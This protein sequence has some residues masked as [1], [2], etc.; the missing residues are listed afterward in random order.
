MSIDISV[1]IFVDRSGDDD[2]D[3]YAYYEQEFRTINAF[4]RTLGLPEHHE[5]LTLDG[6]R[7][8]YRTAKREMYPMKDIASDIEA[9]TVL[10]FPHL[11]ELSGEDAI[12]LPLLFENVLE[13][14]SLRH[15][16]S[17]FKLFEE[18]RLLAKVL[19]IYDEL[20]DD[21]NQWGVV[22]FSRDLLVVQVEGLLDLE[23]KEQNI[24]FSQIRDQMLCHYPLLAQNVWEVPGTGACMNL[25][26][27]AKFSLKHQ[28]ALV[29]H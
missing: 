11:L 3:F 9:Q 8:M 26:E 25:Y 2:S 7:P 10:R 16:G 20:E 21:T 12:Y 18:C 19:G 23:R 27:A 17:S 4:L 29:I 22:S 28:A 14:P 1:G 24:P 5:P 15:I 6:E 13:P